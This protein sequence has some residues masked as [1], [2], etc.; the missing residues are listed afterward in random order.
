MHKQI[1]CKR[2]TRF[3]RGF[4]VN[5]DFFNNRLFYF[6]LNMRK[7]SLRIEYVN[8]HFCKFVFYSFSSLHIHGTE[9][10][11][12]SNKI[13]RALIHSYLQLSQQRSENGDLNYNNSI[14]EMNSN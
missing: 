2:Y 11:V 3:Y 8:F 7:D 5:V 1:F 14:L 13:K 4:I 9:A 10:K 6:G 12:V